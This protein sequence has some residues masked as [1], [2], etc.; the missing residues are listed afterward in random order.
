MP[1]TICRAH[2]EAAHAAKLLDLLH[3]DEAFDAEGAEG[4]V[5]AGRGNDER[6]IDGV[7]IHARLVVVMHCDKCPVGHHASNPHSIRVGGSGSWAGDEVFNSGSVEEL[8][9]GVGEDAGE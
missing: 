3:R 7:G 5:V 4:A 1:P 2:I 8:D 6:R 9:V